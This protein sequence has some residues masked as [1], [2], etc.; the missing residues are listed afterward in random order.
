[1]LNGII[2]KEISIPFHISKDYPIRAILFSTNKNEAYL[3]LTL[4]HHA[5]DAV[6]ADILCE[7][8]SLGYR[9]RYN[10]EVTAASKL[11]I[12]YSDWAVWQYK[13]VEKNLIL[14]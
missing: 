5:S 8:I 10:N 13:E 7:A 2:Q 9:S 3:V 12:Q 14:K 6:S 11:E 1:L 4:H